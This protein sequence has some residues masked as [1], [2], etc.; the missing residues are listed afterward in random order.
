MTEYFYGGRRNKG[1]S[2]PATQYAGGGERR[3]RPVG[4]PVDETFD[5]RSH[6]DPQKVQGSWNWQDQENNLQ[7]HQR[8]GERVLPN[9]NHAEQLG[10]NV[11][12]RPHLTDQIR[13]RD[14]HSDKDVD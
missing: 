3:A 4:C 10:L 6:R 14:D 7:D 11:E 8:S 2:N 1:G 13:Q 9:V 5:R 12:S